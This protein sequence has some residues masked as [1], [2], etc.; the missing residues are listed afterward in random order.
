MFMLCPVRAERMVRTHDATSGPLLKVAR[1]M[2]ALTRA[3]DGFN[4]LVS[5][6]WVLCLPRFLTVSLLVGNCIREDFSTTP[7]VL[8]STCTGTVDVVVP[9]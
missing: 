8:R 5:S 1:Q 6:W 7:N 3:M 2:N 9:C 4:S